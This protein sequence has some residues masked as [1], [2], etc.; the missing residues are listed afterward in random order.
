MANMSQKTTDQK[1]H[2]RTRLKRAMQPLLQRFGCTQMQV[3]GYVDGMLRTNEQQ[4]AKIEELEKAIDEKDG[5]IK[6]LKAEIVEKDERIKEL[7]AR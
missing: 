7:K 4:K 1:R 5:R 6:E 3:A 2:R